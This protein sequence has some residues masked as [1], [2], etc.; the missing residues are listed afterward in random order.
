MK[1]SGKL[2]VSLMCSDLLN[3]EQEIQ[4]CERCGADYLHIDIMDA[5]FVPNLT[6]GPG[7]VNAVRRNTALPLDIHLL[8]EHPC[9]IVRSMEIREG[10]IVTVHVECSD[11]ILDNITI[12]KQKRG[13]FGLALNP[14]TP[15]ECIQEYLPYVDVVLVML[16]APG[17]AGNPMIHDWAE[18][19][20]ET[21][22][23]LE[24]HGHDNVEI[25]ADGGVS[26][27]CAKLLR[28]IGAD[29]FVGGST[30]IFRAGTKTEDNIAAFRKAIASPQNGVYE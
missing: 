27:E 17:F 28:E 3:M 15:I 6:F 24:E 22:R 23:Y 26:I 30:G 25:C 14:G 4:I 21:R 9:R 10:D 13:R 12:I 1:P 5:A 18:R 8:M 7:F 20:G 11:R 2:S 16:T 19:I 29:I